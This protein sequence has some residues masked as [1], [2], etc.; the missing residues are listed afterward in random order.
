MP[1]LVDI[2]TSFPQNYYTQAELIEGILKV[3]KDKIYNPSRLLS[4]NEHVLV[5]GRHLALKI[6]EYFKA[7]TFG[8][9]NNHFIE[10]SLQ[11]ACQA[12]SHLLEKNNLLPEDISALWSNTITGFA[13]PSLEARMMNKLPFKTDTKRV[14]LFG[15]GCM[16][17]AAGVNRVGEY[18]RGHPQEAVIFLSVELCSLTLQ[19]DDLSIPNLISSSLFGDGA[20]AVLMVGDDHFLAP[21]APL[22]WKG[23][24]SEFFPHSEDV[25]GWNVSEQGL[26]IILNKSVPDITQEYLPAPLK[27]F[28]DQN[29]LKLDQ[30][31]T[32]FSHPGG[33][34][35]L[36]AMESVLG[37]PEKGLKHSWESLAENGNMSSVS[38]LDI[39]KRTME[40]KNRERKNHHA[41][42][43][44]MGPAFSAELGLFQ[45]I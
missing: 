22:R 23:A 24:H 34:K 5:N 32:F 43:I 40:E 39:M 13:I 28:L 26:K 7:M 6:D 19:L 41:L 31:A 9:K 20:A 3:W 16:A 44:A 2:Q 37:L 10:C 25:M 17:G 15:L 11:L 21:Q 45:W 30:I 35:V 14:P 4:I 8:Q 33:P 42:S 29:S 27:K 12:V 36:M 1:Y 38:V 18:L